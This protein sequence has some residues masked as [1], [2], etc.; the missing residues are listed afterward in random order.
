[1]FGRKKKKADL[2]WQPDAAT[3]KALSGEGDDQGGSSDALVSHEFGPDHRPDDIAMAHAAQYDDPYAARS[4][5]SRDPRGGSND[6]WSG[7]VHP[8]AILRFIGGNLKMIVMMTLV[9][10]LAGFAIYLILPEKYGTTALILVDPRQPRITN[11][12]TV[13]SGIGGD[14]AA[15]TSYVEIMNSDGFLSKVVDELGVKEDPDF[16]KA[17]NE[18]ELISMFR[19]NLSAN[20]QG[21]TYIVQV[22]YRSKNP[23][24]AAKYANGVAKAFVRDQRD[25]RTA[26]NEEATEW[27]SERLKLLRSNLKVSEDAVAAFQARNGIVDTGAQGTLDNQQLTSLVSRL[28]IASTEYVEARSRYEQASKDGVPA[29]ADSSQSGQFQV[30]DQLLQEQGRLRRQA[31]ELGQTFGSRHPRMLAITEQQRI[32]AGQIRQER[33]R[34]VK[35]TKQAFETAEARKTAIEQQLADARQRSIQLNKAMVELATLEREATA[36]RNLYEQFLARY[37]ITDEQSRFQFSEARIVSP[38]PVPSKSTKPSM[39]LVL[40]VL[41]VLGLGFGLLIALI[42][43]AFSQPDPGGD[44]YGGSDYRRQPMRQPEGPQS[45]P[46]P[47]SA[48]PPIAASASMMD[49]PFADEERESALD[50]SHGPEGEDEAAA[51][52]QFDDP[53]GADASMDDDDDHKQPD[54]VVPL[55]SVMSAKRFHDAAA[56]KRRKKPLTLVASNQ[57]PVS[58]TPKP[59]APAR[60]LL[61]MPSVLMML[62]AGF[63]EEDDG[64]LDEL[65]ETNGDAIE[66]FIAKDLEQESVS[67]L[68][69]AAQA[70]E[71]QTL[72]ADVLRE[73]A[74]DSGFH[75]VII[76]LKDRAEQAHK[77]RSGSRAKPPDRVARLQVYEEFD[78]IPFVTAKGI[79]SAQGLTPALSK[80]LGDLIA[81]CRENYGFVILET[82]QIVDPEALEDLIDL[83]DTALLVLKDA[84]LSDEDL[85]DWQLWAENAGVALVLDQTQ[86]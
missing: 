76:S 81:L 74:I 79:S 59:A 66:H 60:D 52:A 53:V 54:P 20:R 72:T 2:D 22:Y 17:K 41:L 32:I 61:S 45:V 46:V 18:G 51:T 3:S 5:T 39:T 7:L 85:E 62:P 34:L 64:L 4:V 82:R 69:T 47:T 42:R 37:K 68:V 29:S 70:G 55:R 25:Y 86:I 36:N 24:S 26:T 31:A 44:P 19:S 48:P 21:A 83:V 63:N 12:D 40:P 9:V 15:L 23:K 78:I 58:R 67:L 50:D 57:E 75:P 43:E 27:L 1:M 30:L 8:R 35:Q 33:S 56:P 73:F 77:A 71:G 49:E 80:E 11:S 14:A 13:I 65:V 84:E 10:F 16:A 28:A 38:A 6:V